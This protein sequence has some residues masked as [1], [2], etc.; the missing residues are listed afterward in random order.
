MVAVLSVPEQWFL[1]LLGG[2][3]LRGPAGV[4]D[5]APGVQRLLAYV[6]LQGGA[7]PRLRT[8]RQLWPDLAPAQGA[9]NLRSTLWRMRQVGTL[10]DAGAS[11]LRLAGGVTV[12]VHGLLAERPAAGMGGTMLG[13]SSNLELLPEWGEDWVT[14]ERERL[15]HL[16]LQVLDA[17][18]D[19]LVRTGRVVEALDTALRAIRLEPLRESSHRA[20]IRIFLAS[21]NRSAAL[22]HYHGL[23]ALLRDELDLGPAPD[24]T[25]L[26]QPF[27]SSRA[28]AARAGRPG[29]R[30]RIKGRGQRPRR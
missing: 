25:A 6:A 10:V 19:S 24:T 4:V 15:R 23:V 18:V 29:G 20:V 22:T 3:E 12:D 14:V 13:S 1:G 7:A 8:A 27:L 26:V 5:V 17:R 28:G 9:A 21:G 11:T 30:P 2:F 16:E